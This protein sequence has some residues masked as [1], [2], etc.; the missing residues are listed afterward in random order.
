MKFIPLDRVGA[1]MLFAPMAGVPKWDISD[2]LCSIEQIVGNGQAFIAVDECDC[3]GLMLFVVDWAQQAHGRELVIRVAKQ[4]SQRGD[5][6]E[7]VLPEIERVFG[8]GCDVVTVYTR[9]A[10]LVAKLEKSGYS[11]AAKIMRKK[12]R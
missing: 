2:G 6:V 3:E 9:R 11:E 12:I 5:L 8:G 1:L 10:G 4:L 7:T